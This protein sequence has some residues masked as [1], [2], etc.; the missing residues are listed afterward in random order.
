MAQVRIEFTVEPFVEGHPGPHV[1]AAIGA[2]EARGLSVDVGPFSSVA[3]VSPQ[4]AG[5][6]VAELLDAALAEGA[7][8]VS[9]QVERV[10]E[11]DG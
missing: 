10:A 1:L 4:A 9:L 8:R 11:A 5:A 7:T 2:V 3:V 6:T